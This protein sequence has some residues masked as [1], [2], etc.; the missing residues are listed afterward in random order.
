MEQQ[1]IQLFTENN[2][3]LASKLIRGKRTLY[4]QLKTLLESGKAIQ[5]KR[6]LYRHT[7]F[8]EDAQLGEV[9]RMV[10]QGVLCLFSAW[11]FY[12]LSTNVSSVIH[13][14][15]PGRKKP[16]LPAFPPVKIY[17]WSGDYFET[18]KIEA[19]HNGQQISIYNLEKSVCDAIRYRNKAG[20]EIVVEV[21]RNYLGRKDRNLD[22]LMKYADYMRITNTMSHYLNL[23]L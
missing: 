23:L 7:D 21:L 4:Y 3:Y 18:G 9:C 12:N 8:Q 14:A 19:T 10:P 6:G 11:H 16:I 17:F 15:I 1:L 5:I 20:T 2:G 13:L 22:K